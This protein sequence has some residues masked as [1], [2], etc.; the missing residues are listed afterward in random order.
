MPDR[1]LITEGRTLLA[2]ATPGPWDTD[3]HAHLEKGCRCLSCHDSATVTLTTNMLDCQDIPGSD[4]QT[5][6]E[7]SGYTWA[8]AELIVWMR[9]SL[10]ALLAETEQ[11][12]EGGKYL[13]EI[14]HRQNRMALDATG[15]HHLIDGDGD[16]D[17]QA[18]WETLAELGAAHQTL[19]TER[20]GELAAIAAKQQ[21]DNARLGSYREAMRDVR[22]IIADFG[23]TNPPPRL[24]A[25]LEE[26]T[27]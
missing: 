23:I 14:V 11:L 25:L 16:G 27:L 24:R 20:A 3:P 15:L 4:D 18:V 6:C 26:E 12:R 21:R 13:G 9:N 19:H 10:P 17:W 8:D 7:Q 1:D 5:R 2:A 22:R